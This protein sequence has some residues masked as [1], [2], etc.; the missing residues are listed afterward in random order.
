MY[1][2][3]FDVRATRKELDKIKQEYPDIHKHI[4]VADDWYPN[5]PDG[6]VEATI[7]IAI[8]IDYYQNKRKPERPKYYIKFV[9]WGYDDDGM[10]KEFESDDFDKI[11]IQRDEW[12][13]YLNKVPENIELHEYLY[14]DGFVRG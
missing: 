4:K 12:I 9:F 2:N 6:T 13:E 10:E 14:K 3:N 1:S 11:L 8:D 7:L 5:Y